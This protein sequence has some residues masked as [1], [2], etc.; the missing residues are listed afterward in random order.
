[1]IIKAENTGSA[2]IRGCDDDP[3]ERLHVGFAESA[4]S[5]GTETVVNDAQGEGPESK[6]AL[7]ALGQA[8]RRAAVVLEQVDDTDGGSHALDALFDLDD[9]LQEGSALAGLLP[10]LLAAARPGDDLAGRIEDL[11]RQLTAVTEQVAK[12][13][14]VLKELRATEE[15]LRDR[16]AEHAPL[17]RQV[18]ELRRLKRRVLD[19]DALQEQHDVIADR[20]AA[21]SGRDAGVDEALRTSSE[22]LV[23]LSEKQLAALSPRTQRILARADEVQ[24][25]LAAAEREHNE[26]A[27]ELA[28][29]KAQLEQIQETHGA[30]LASL[31]K[32]AAA[33]R[34]L[35]HAL[36][37]PQ[38]APSGTDTP[39]QGLS[40]A[41]V[42][43]ATADMERRLRAADDVLCRVVAERE[44][45]DRDGRFTVPWSG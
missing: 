19:L 33:D 25:E 6:S 40:L 38:G 37:E 16:L 4:H 18:D 31:Q 42:E 23:R 8:F 41:E 45:L 35:A 36:G 44:A 17:S 2:W 26:R 10:G 30:Q 29:C 39:Q 11:M 20:L 3:A 22:A 13:R 27:A 21:L 1:M 43:A 7:K 32:Y 15:E 9:A 24:G 14:V 12:E 28:A 5:K 34:D